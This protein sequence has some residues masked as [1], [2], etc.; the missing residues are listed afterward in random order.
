MSKPS[1][2]SEPM[3]PACLACLR[4]GWT[5]IAVFLVGGLVLESFHFVKLPFY[6][7]S[8]LRRE[9]WTLAHAH[10]T[11][12]GAINVIFALTAARH[13]SEGARRA[14][15]AALLRFGAP[16]VPVGFFLGGFGAAEGDP[17][18]FVVL[19]PIGG[20][21]CAVAVAMLA[22]DLLRPRTE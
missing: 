4:L 2:P 8:R 19:V 7:D 5:M 9:L 22:R 20:G 11:L 17:S 21:L 12:L 13:M 10:G 3:D 15:A 1:R 16:L 6:E 14:R 18:L